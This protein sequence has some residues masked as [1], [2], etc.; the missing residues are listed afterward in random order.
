MLIHLHGLVMRPII[1][2]DPNEYLGSTTLMALAE[3]RGWLVLF[4]FGQEG[5]SWFDEVGMTNIMTLVRTAKIDFNIDDDRVYMSGFSDGASAAFL[6]AMVMPTDFAAFVA[7]NGYMGV[8]SEDG[9]LPTYATNMANTNIYVTTTDRDNF[10]PTSQMQRSISMAEKAGAKILYRRLTGQHSFSDIEGELPAI[11]DYL[12]QHP[13]NSFPD[14]VVWETAVAGFGVCKWLAIDEITIDEPAEWHVD[15]NV[16]LVDSTI[17][18]GFQPYD[19]F[20]GPGVMVASL[21]NG[22]YLARRIDLKPGDVI[23]KGNNVSIDSLADLNRFK[24]TLQ[25]G[26]EVALTVKR[27]GS[28]VILRGRVP[29]PRNY[30]VFKRE[31]P[32]AMIKASFSN[33]RFNMQGSR[34]GAFRILISPEKIDLNKNVVVTFNGEKIFDGKITPDITCMLRDY[35]ANRDRKLVFVN[36]IKLRPNR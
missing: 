15:Y 18:I 8:G 2:P 36:E 23:V 27:V 35:L 26:S 13:R 30:F 34:V 7:L 4:P 11:F 25:R 10:Y 6:F 24:G 33:N 22:D 29:A 31:Q 5:A 21:A 12:E 14:T 19:T 3:K 17:A 32:S 9:G 28:E 20:P 1:D 16:A